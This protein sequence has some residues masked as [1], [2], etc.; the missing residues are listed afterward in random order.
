M[1]VGPAKKESMVFSTFIMGG[2]VKNA[3]A[4]DSSETRLCCGAASAGT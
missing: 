3:G 2:I 1:R 4:L